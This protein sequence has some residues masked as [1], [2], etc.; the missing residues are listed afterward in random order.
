[1]SGVSEVSDV[2]HGSPT[3]P[4]G[5]PGLSAEAQRQRLADPDRCP[6][7]R[8]RTIVMMARDVRNRLHNTFCLDLD[9]L[10]MWLA[11]I[12]VGHVRPELRTKIVAY[13]C[14]C[15]EVRP[16]LARRDRGQPHGEGV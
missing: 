11:T 9:I 3:G 14:E 5:A 4:C 15:A 7:A 1:M 13:Q 10:P 12:S 8:G 16:H 6:W 2:G